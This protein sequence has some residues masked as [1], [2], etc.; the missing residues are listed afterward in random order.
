MIMVML[1]MVVMT[2]SFES[3]TQMKIVH[4]AYQEG[5]TIRFLV[6]EEAWLLREFQH[7]G[8]I[9]REKQHSLQERQANLSL[10]SEHG[11]KES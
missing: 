4:L 1:V 2:L 7:Q 9:W 3:L 5:V 10:H 6:L 8:E 11:H